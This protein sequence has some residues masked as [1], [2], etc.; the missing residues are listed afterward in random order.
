[1]STL[2]RLRSRVQ[3]LRE[4]VAYRSTARAAKLAGAILAAA[5]VASLTIDLG[6]SVRALGERRGSEALK[7]P[8]HIGRLSIHVLR[9]SVVV[10]DLR[11]D[12][13]NPT[14]RPFFVA[15]RIELGLE[16]SSVFRRRPEFIISS[17][18]MTDWQMLIEKWPGD[19]N[20]FPRFVNNDQPDSGPRRLI[21]PPTPPAHIRAQP[22]PSVRALCAMRSCESLAASAPNCGSRR[23]SSSVHP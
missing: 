6:P 4:H 2:Q 7:R 11:I 3:L 10:D 13:V 15:K 20:N 12:G 23:R 19:K 16:W 14:D 5:I 22:P 18:E 1:V 17:V 21:R 9:G 8:I